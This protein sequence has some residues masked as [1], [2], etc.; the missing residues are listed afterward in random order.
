MELLHSDTGLFKKI[1]SFISSANNFVLFSPYI[2]EAILS[3][4]FKDITIS[5]HNTVVTSWKPQDIVLGVSDI[6]IY[7]LCKEKGV[8]LLLNNRI[9]LKSYI[10]NDF[11]T[12]II[13]SSNITA[14]GLAVNPN[15]NFELGVLVEGLNVEDKTYFDKIIEQSEE[16]TQSYYEQ[17]KEQVENLDLQKDMPED[18]K[19]KKDPSEKEFLITALPMSDNME[20]LFDVYNGNHNYDEETLRSAEHD[21]RIYKIPYGYSE[22]EF[23]II[24]KKNYFNHPFILKFLEFIDDGKYF[25]EAT[26][27]LH[28]NC[29]TV[30][31]P[32]RYEIKSALKRIFKFT[33]TLSEGFYVIEVPKRHSMFL[34]KQ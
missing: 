23:R 17:V 8:T 11:K 20:L 14:R 12:C 4:L 29:T 26:E 28:K 9:H 31:T 24:L 21:I 7:P 13:T 3:K 5:E 33:E 32:R 15:F 10:I 25:G 19:I 22:Q 18:F 6:E 2:K 27:W 1:R 34:K 16:I 30:P